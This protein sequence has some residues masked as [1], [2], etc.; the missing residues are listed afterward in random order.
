MAASIARGESQRSLG[1]R[2]CLDVDASAL[3]GS[4]RAYVESVPDYV[5]F[6]FGE[7]MKKGRSKAADGASLCIHHILLRGLITATSGLARVKPKQLSAAVLQVLG[8]SRWAYR[9]LNRTALPNEIFADKM[10]IKIGIMLSHLRRLKSQ[11]V[12]KGSC[13][14]RL[15]Q[16][17]KDILE[18]L[19]E[20]ILTQ[21]SRAHSDSSSHSCDDYTPPPKKTKHSKAETDT[22][23]DAWLKDLPAT[24][25]EPEE[26]EWEASL[27]EESNPDSNPDITRAAQAQGLAAMGFDK[28]Y[29]PEQDF[30]SSQGF[31]N[32]LHLMLRVRPGGC[33][34][35]AP[36][37]KTWIWLSRT[38]TRRSKYHPEGDMAKDYVKNA[39]RMVILLSLLFSVAFCRGVALFMEQPSSTVLHYMSPMNYVIKHCLPYKV[40]TY[41]GAFGAE[42]AKPVLIWSSLQEVEQLKRARPTNLE[43]LTTRDGDQVTGKNKMLKLSQAYPE[44]F[45]KAVS[46][47]WVLLTGIKNPSTPTSRSRAR[48]TTPSSS[49]S[50]ATGTPSCLREHMPFEGVDW[51]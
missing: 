5:V 24:C 23:S 43:K 42:S 35:A 48:T 16:T 12:K 4:F 44:G 26:W 21:K 34:W 11:P 38:Q 22:D 8:D 41:L 6:D 15:D 1:R 20:G 17:Q 40:L 36:E 45:G 10:Q 37:C 13:F 29:S 33:L 32:A 31:M 25:A 30:T 47:I 9:R 46:E 3:A 7:Y 51:D 27:I 2:A 19:L 28:V 14:N 49:T 39:N 50:T 18:G